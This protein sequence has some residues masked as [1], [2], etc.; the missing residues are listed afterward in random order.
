M[1]GGTEAID[2]CEAHRGGT[3]LSMIQVRMIQVLCS[4]N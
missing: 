3:T 1:G 2:M 4:K